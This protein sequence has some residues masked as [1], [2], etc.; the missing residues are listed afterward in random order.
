[1]SQ[2][3]KVLQDIVLIQTA[4]ILVQQKDQKKNQKKTHTFMV[5]LIQEM[6]RCWRM[7]ICF[8]KEWI[9]DNISQK[10]ID[11]AGLSGV[12]IKCNNLQSVSKITE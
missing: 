7:F 8:Y 5:I 4:R 2:K 3:M 11:F 9:E 1:M 12:T 10:S 6:K